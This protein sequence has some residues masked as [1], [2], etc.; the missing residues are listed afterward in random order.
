MGAV[1]F[2]AMCTNQPCQYDMGTV[3]ISVI[4]AKHDMDTVFLFRTILPYTKDNYYTLTV[5]LKTNLK[6]LSLCCMASVLD[7][8]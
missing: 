1:S 5:F 2:G 3:S 8:G 6:G 4:Y 7:F